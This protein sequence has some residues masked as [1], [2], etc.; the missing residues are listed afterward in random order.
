MNAKLDIDPS[1][2]TLPFAIGVTNYYNVR[3]IMFS[4][5]CFHF[6]VSFKRKRNKRKNIF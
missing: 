1:L 4:F 6:S 3:E 5:L 2:T